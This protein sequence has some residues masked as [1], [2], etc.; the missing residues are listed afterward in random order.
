M[1]IGWWEVDSRSL[2]PQP[3]ELVPYT[4]LCAG[5]GVYVPVQNCY[6][7]EGIWHLS[8]GHPI[9]KKVIARLYLPGVIVAED[10]DLNLT[11]PAISEIDQ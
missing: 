2:I 4:I 10:V 9:R 3:H 8:T 6:L 7:R 11:V 1:E 5:D